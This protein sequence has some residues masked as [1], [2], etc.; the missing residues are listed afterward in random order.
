[1]EFED[2]MKP[3]NKTIVTLVAL[4]ACLYW[5]LTF[6]KNGAAEV[7][8]AAPAVKSPKGYFVLRPSQGPLDLAKNLLASKNV[9]GFELRDRWINI[10]K[11]PKRYDFS[12]L[13]AGAEICR[14]AGKQYT[15]VVEAGSQSPTWLKSKGCQTVTV[16]MEEFD[17]T[18][19]VPVPWDPVFKRYYSDMVQALGAEFDKDP[20]CVKINAGGPQRRSNE[21]HLKIPA[22]ERMTN[23]A[24]KLYG[25][26]CDC[27]DMY[28]KAFPTTPISL[29]L[30]N[31]FRPSDGI[32]ERVAKRHAETF[33]FYRACFQYDG[34]NAKPDAADFG[35]FKL[36]QQYGQR[37][38]MSGVEQ[39]AG[40]S[41]RNGFKRYGGSG[42]A[43]QRFQFSVDRAAY[44]GCD[45]FDLYELDLPLLK[46]K[47]IPR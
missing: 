5:L 35:P 4:L 38:Y 9:A 27:L 33:G 29:N 16:P 26:W 7:A 31:P 34:Y 42:T 47:F 8:P 25:A 19:I 20:L 40:V 41:G 13:K 3:R 30:A 28:G 21:M 14:K 37:G 44:V 43:Q 17:S 12:R 6:S 24:E 22:I 2:G 1:L 45:F 18:N 32:M 10:E 39:V 15:L 46:G 36:V 11:Q 23:S